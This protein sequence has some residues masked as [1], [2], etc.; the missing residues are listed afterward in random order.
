MAPFLASTDPLIGVGQWSIKEGSRDAFASEIELLLVAILD[1]S[2]QNSID[3]EEEEV[4]IS[5]SSVGGLSIVWRRSGIHS[6]ESAG[7]FLEGVIWEELQLEK[8]EE[9]EEHCVWRN[10]WLVNEV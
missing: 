4:V 5:G 9:A 1:S 2:G 7:H 8:Q 6:T 10:V 3:G